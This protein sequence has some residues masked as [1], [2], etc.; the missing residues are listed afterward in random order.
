[1]TETEAH[2]EDTNML[3]SS[4]D[5]DDSDDSDST[6]E[7]EKLATKQAEFHAKYGRTYRKAAL[8]P[9]EVLESPEYLDPSL[10]AAL[11]SHCR[12]GAE[13]DP[14]PPEFS[15]EWACLVSSLL[16]SDFEDIKPAVLN[17]VWGTLNFFLEGDSKVTHASVAQ[18]MITMIIVNGQGLLDVPSL[19]F[20]YD[21]ANPY[22]HDAVIKTFVARYFDGD[23][24]EFHKVF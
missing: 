14:I 10:K 7:R 23:F 24:V 1:M 15:I 3:T 22:D 18:F 20:F 17:R 2:L 12:G 9:D 19:R 8:V 16:S 5:S 4:E 13:F 6:V 21:A 11:L